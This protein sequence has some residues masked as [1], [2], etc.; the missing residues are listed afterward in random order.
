MK[1]VL[2]GIL[3]L[4]MV[5]TLVGCRNSSGNSSG[6]SIDELKTALVKEIKF[7]G[8]SISEETDGLSFQAESSSYSTD[9]SITGT[10]DKERN[11]NY[12][13]IENAGVPLDHIS[14]AGSISPA[15]LQAYYQKFMENGMQMTVSEL[16]A[17]C[18]IG[19]MQALYSLFSANREAR[20]DFDTIF[21]ALSSKDT[22]SI[23]NWTISVSVDWNNHIVTIEGSY[24]K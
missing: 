16:G 6:I 2:I 9:I 17:L 24:K 12:I 19:E 10:A 18:C 1:R 15:A 20:A 5:F 21:N 11:V 3:A 7:D 8:F 23:N 14:T 4:A 22:T 13:K